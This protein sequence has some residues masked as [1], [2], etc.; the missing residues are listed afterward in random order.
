MHTAQMSTRVTRKTRVTEGG[1]N[2]LRNSFLGKPAG[3][4]VKGLRVAWCQ[5]DVLWIATSLRS[6]Q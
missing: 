4:A 6:S 2:C 1:L 3:V 5:G